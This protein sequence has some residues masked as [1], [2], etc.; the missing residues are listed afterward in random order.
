MLSR[1]RCLQTL[2]VAASLAAARSATADEK[3]SDESSPG[4]SRIWIF[5]KPI[6]QLTF[7]E[8]AEWLI[9]WDVGGLEATARRG[10]WIEPADAPSKLPQ[11]VEA[12]QSVDRTGL[13]VTTDVNR[14]DQPDVDLV[15]KSASQ[16]GVRYFRMAYYKY[17]FSKKILPQ[18]D[19]FAAQATQLAEICKQLKM[20]AL[21][22]N[23]AGANYVGA[24]LWDLMHVLQGIDP[25]AMSIAID[26]RHTTIEA[27]ES[28]RAG[29]ARIKDSV[30]A[31][32]VKDAIYVDGA[33][34]DGPLGR[35]E[36]CKQL[37]KLVQADHPT[38]P[39]S[40]HMEH[41]DH[42]P[43]ELLPQ[44]LAAITADVETLKRWLIPVRR[45]S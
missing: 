7:K 27:A 18:L 25:S 2:A 17:D 11:L 16:L 10:G 31:M 40:L 1:R 13:I 23:H 30:G 39:M 20:T 36:K 3:P 33:V 6:E 24:P 29:Y 26:L 45:P 12:L 8:V 42:R 5:T 22:Q 21:Y 9:R 38:I 28:W 41:I 34:N 19:A 44:R 37:F 14:A 15:L 32:F 43:K 35:S 4:A